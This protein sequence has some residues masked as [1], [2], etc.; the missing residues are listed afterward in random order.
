MSRWVLDVDSRIHRSQIKTCKWWKRMYILMGGDK[1]LFKC[2]YFWVR[3]LSLSNKQ[4]VILRTI[5][6]SGPQ[7]LIHANIYSSHKRWKQF[8][9]I[10]IIHLL[11]TEATWEGSSEQSALN[12]AKHV[13]CVLREGEKCMQVKVLVWPKAMLMFALHSVLFFMLIVVLN[14]S[15]SW[16]QF[17]LIYK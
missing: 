6:E 3:P 7:A 9:S 11:W 16:W 4:V 14:C 15:N 17:K 10:H 5:D 8:T 12:I 2:F 1:T 13:L